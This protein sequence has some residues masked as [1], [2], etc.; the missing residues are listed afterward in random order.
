MLNLSINCYKH[1]N[2]D[3]ILI[4]FPDIK[5]NGGYSTLA[6]RSELLYL[7]DVHQLYLFNLIKKQK[8]ISE[9]F[10]NGIEKRF[11]IYI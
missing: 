8:N 9:L 6:Y 11:I 3:F 5:T 1:I 7:R 4:S 10:Q 2:K